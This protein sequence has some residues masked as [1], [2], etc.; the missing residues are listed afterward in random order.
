MDRKIQV[1][2]ANYVEDTGTISYKFMFDC[3]P[4]AASGHHN[5]P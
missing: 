4:P 5:Q 1:V 2:T 3:Q